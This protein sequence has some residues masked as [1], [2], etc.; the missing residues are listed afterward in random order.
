MNGALAV[1]E[2]WFRWRDCVVA[3]QLCKTQFCGATPGKLF[4]LLI[5]TLAASALPET[6]QPT[7]FGKSHGSFIDDARF[8]QTTTQLSIR[9]DGSG[10]ARANARCIQPD[11]GQSSAGPTDLRPVMIAEARRRR[12]P[13]R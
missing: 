12:A 3:E 2:L 6:H 11:R 7:F 8:S 4:K 5:Y 13:R 1:C 9:H 10:H